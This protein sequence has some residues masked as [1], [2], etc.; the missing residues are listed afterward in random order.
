MQLPSFVT[1][2]AEMVFCAPLNA[3]FGKETLHESAAM[4]SFR[5]TLLYDSGCGRDCGIYPCPNP[6]V[7]G[8]DGW[9]EL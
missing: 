9:A 5:Y 2:A 8:K 6:K 3:C 1:A 7:G 4:A